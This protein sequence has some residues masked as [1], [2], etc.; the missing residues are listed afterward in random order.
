MYTTALRTLRNAFTMRQGGFQNRPGTS[1]VGTTKL[2]GRTVRMIEWIFNAEQ[3][4]VLEFGHLYMRVISDGA[5]IESSPGVPYEI[6]TPY[7]EDDLEELNYTQSADVMTIVHRSYAPRELS[8]LAETNWTLAIITFGPAI[9]AL[10]GFAG[11]GAT[12]GFAKNTWWVTA[13]NSGGEESLAVAVT[14][15]TR[16]SAGTPISLSWTA[17]ADAIEYRLYKALNPYTGLGTALDPGLTAA[18]SVRG[19]LKTLDPTTNGFTDD[20][21]TDEN[22]DPNFIPPGTTA[23]NPFSAAGDYPGAVIYSQQRRIFAS[24]T[25]NPERCWASYLGGY[26]NFEI[27][28]EI[29]DSCHVQF[30]LVGRQVNEIMHLIETRQLLALTIG[31][32]WSINGND[33]GVITPTAV[34]PKQQTYYGA[35]FIR[36]LNIGE[37]VYFIQGRGTRVRSLGFDFGTDGYRAPDLTIFSSHLFDKYT[38]VD[39]AYQQNPHSIIW[40]V[41]S[42]GKLLGLTSIKDQEMLAWHRHDFSGGFVENV[43]VIPEGTEDS[44][45]L[46]IRR[47]IDGSTVRYIERMNTRQLT[48]QSGIFSLLSDYSDLTGIID[49]IFMDSALSYDGRNTAAVITMTLSGGS[50]WDHLE[51]LTLTASTSFFVSGDVGNEVHITDPGT[52]AVIRCEIVEFTSVTVVFV[53]A[54]TEVPVGLRTVATTNWGKAVDALSGLDHLEG[55][56]VSIIGDGFVVASPN[57]DQYPVHTVVGGAVTLAV[58]RVVIHVG[59]PYFSDAETLDIDNTSGETM[60]DKSK[61]ITAVSVHVEETRGIWVG[62]QPPEDDDEDPLDGL[63]EPAIRSTETY[64]EP[65]RLVSE[66]VSDIAIPGQSNLNGRVFIRQVDPLPMTILSIV[67]SGFIPK[68]G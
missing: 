59:L 33:V 25:N 67:P 5:H 23:R 1:Y 28:D 11:S 16:A 7:D 40:A 45:Y 58:P 49:C 30:D 46:V 34:N 17:N 22:I 54:H 19:L 4:Y 10:A 35:R 27:Y 51:N 12:G 65:T 62:G 43:C 6:V 36:P 53:R 9:A 15:N 29:T 24:S 61:V 41:R 31:S 18:D 50:T 48:A 64:D 32:E 44:L 20:G 38:L 21:S 57:N 26:S 56:D 66:V 39:W 55:E 63:E 68:A 2:A 14:S 42:D 52:G 3:A 60:S 47:E 13:V 8:R 37:E